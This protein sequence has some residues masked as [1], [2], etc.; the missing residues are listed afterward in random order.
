MA[1]LVSEATN[2]RVLT[3]CTFSRESTLC[4]FS[5]ILYG[6]PIQ[7]GVVE[8]VHRHK[9]SPRA[10]STLESTVVIS[11]LIHLDVSSLT[12][13]DVSSSTRLDISSLTWFDVS[14][15]LDISTPKIP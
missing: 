10:S 14:S 9:H 13:L 5:S 2:G 15:R 11:S 3:L 7:V 8:L 4:I 12:R 1:D 6:C